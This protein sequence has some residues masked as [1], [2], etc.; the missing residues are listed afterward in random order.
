MYPSLLWDLLPRCS[1]CR[2]VDLGGDRLRLDVAKKSNSAHFSTW[3]LQRFVSFTAAA[4]SAARWPRR[5]PCAQGSCSPRA[6][7]PG[8]A[9]SATAVCPHPPPATP[10]PRPMRQAPRSPATAAHPRDS[11]RQRFHTA[12]CQNRPSRGPHPGRHRHHRPEPSLSPAFR[13]RWRSL[14]LHAQPP[15][16]PLTLRPVLP[17]LAEA[18]PSHG[19]PGPPQRRSTPR[20]PPC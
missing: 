2:T 7:A 15:P 16:P 1:A 18:C 3:V 19:R 17:E 10:A 5:S 8:P 14:R 12:A 9:R 13:H 11:T 6:P 4:A 20:A